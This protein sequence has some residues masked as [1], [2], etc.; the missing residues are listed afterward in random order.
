MLMSY[1]R[2]HAISAQ[3]VRP[4]FVTPTKYWR[5]LV[6]FRVDDFGKTDRWG[7]IDDALV[8]LAQAADQQGVTIVS[9]VLVVR[10][11][12]VAGDAAID[13]RRSH[14]EGR[15]R[16]PAHLAIFENDWQVARYLGEHA[17]QLF[18][19]HP[20]PPAITKH[21]PK[22]SISQRVRED[23]LIGTRR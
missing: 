17:T 22:Q 13:V 15:V 23:T 16:H 5:C 3:Q 14:I 4:A 9:A 12:K 2:S 1:K 20:Q 7:Q 10:A 11:E 6:D 21:T 18:Y 8:G 19:V